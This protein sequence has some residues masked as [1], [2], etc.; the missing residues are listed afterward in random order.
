MFQSSHP[1]EMIIK[2]EC[3]PIKAQERVKV[4]LTFPQIPETEK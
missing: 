2:Q 3:V 1:E 4:G